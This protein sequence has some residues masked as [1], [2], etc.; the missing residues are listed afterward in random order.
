[1]YTQEH[2]GK[3]KVANEMK[4]EL[5]KLQRLRDQVRGWVA[6]A[7]PPLCDRLLQ[8][9]QAVENEMERFREVERTL[10][11]RN[12]SKAGLLMVRLLYGSAY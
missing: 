10:K 3:E 11:I 2:A 6:D 1:M 4:K 12:F 5:K 7:P 9:R 8:A